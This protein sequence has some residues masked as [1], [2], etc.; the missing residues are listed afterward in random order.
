MAS[1]YI[2]YDRHF[3]ERLHKRLRLTRD[4]IIQSVIAIAESEAFLDRP[5]RITPQLDSILSKLNSTEPSHLAAR[6]SHR[7]YPAP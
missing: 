5:G 2:E 6:F 7:S 3:L 1:L 4:C